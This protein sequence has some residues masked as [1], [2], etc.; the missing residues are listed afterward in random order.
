M[1]IFVPLFGATF[2]LS[3]TN[4]ETSD[5][6]LGLALAAGHAAL[7]PGI[8]GLYRRQYQ[9]RRH[10]DATEFDTINAELRRRDHR[11]GGQ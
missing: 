1:Q 4:I 10:F 9:N 2:T 5:G 6:Y 8:V 7:D 11:A 3:P